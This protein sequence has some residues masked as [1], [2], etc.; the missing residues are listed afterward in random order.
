VTRR[1][2]PAS[3]YES[4]VLSEAAIGGVSWD[5]DFGATSVCLGCL[6]D[7]DFFARGEIPTQYPAEHG[8]PATV[9][10]VVRALG[11]RGR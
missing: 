9:A 1:L 8:R 11:E 7:L 10:E 2:I 5:A 6:W 4:L 3:C